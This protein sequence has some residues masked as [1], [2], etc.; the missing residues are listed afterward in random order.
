MTR[1]YGRSPRGARL[2][3]RVPYGRWETTT[4]LGAMRS[5]G[6]IAP[7]CVEG[8]I[9]GRVFLAWVQQQLVPALQAGDVIVM[10]N[11]S[12]H[13][14]PGVVAAMNGTYLSLTPLAISR[15]ASCRGL[16]KT[17]YLLEC[18]FRRRGS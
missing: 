5:S 12:S 7:L 1:T 18:R 15:L 13:K 9:N 3:A 2:V 8:A 6:F 11:L 4:F 14:A 16:M 17:P 10:D